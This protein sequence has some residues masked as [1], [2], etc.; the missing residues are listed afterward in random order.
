[1]I[2]AYISDNKSVN[3]IFKANLTFIIKFKSKLMKKIKKKKKDNLNLS[4]KVQGPNRTLFLN[5]FI[6]SYAIYVILNLY[7]L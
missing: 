2:F 6:K 1:M 3:E 7:F 4:K 5:L